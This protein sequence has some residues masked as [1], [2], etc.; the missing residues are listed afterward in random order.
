P[1]SRSWTSG[2]H[3]SCTRGER[4]H[5]SRIH[6]LHDATDVCVRNVTRVRIMLLRGP[7][8]L[9]GDQI[10]AIRSPLFH[11]HYHPLIVVVRNFQR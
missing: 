9:M 11:P 4:R 7:R 2:E 5:E 8:M 10:I 6:A 1:A 3:T